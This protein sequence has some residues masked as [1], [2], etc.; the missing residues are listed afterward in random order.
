MIPKVIHYNFGLDP[1]FCKKPFA[2]FHYLN[3][4]SARRINPDYT[5]NLYYHY[6]PDHLYF[7]KLSDIC[8]LIKIEDLEI[9]DKNKFAYTEHLSDFLR[10]TLLNQIGGIYL[11]IDTIC[12]KSFDDLLHHKF[13]MGYEMA[14]PNYIKDEILIGL[15]NSTMMSEQRSKFSQLWLDDYET[16]YNG[17]WNFNSVKRPLALS[18]E[19]PDLIHIEPKDSFFKYPWDHVGKLQLFEEELD[20]NDCYSLHLWECTNYS[21]LASYTP[22][23]IQNTKNT[24]TN[25]YKQFLS[26]AD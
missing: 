3:V 7:D 20:V 19:Y 6:K 17:D 4:L 16:N 14:R 15:G 25:I 1:F 5:I 13:V 26:Y 23:I 22:S 12:V 24:V 2:Y 8:N 18:S 9:Y 11:D 10:L 21:I